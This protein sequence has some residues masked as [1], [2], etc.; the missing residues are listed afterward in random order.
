MASRVLGGRSAQAVGK[1]PLKLS[2]TR[3]VQSG[4]GLTCGDE[5]SVIPPFNPPAAFFML[6]V[7]ICRAPVGAFRMGG[8]RLQL[9]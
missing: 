9:F 1:P 5:K 4:S 7:D 6:F 2:L 3:C 8:G